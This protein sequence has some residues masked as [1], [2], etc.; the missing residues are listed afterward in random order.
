MRVHFESSGITVLTQ[1][2]VVVVFKIYIRVESA[3]SF[4]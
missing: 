4:V 1:V 2:V 3:T